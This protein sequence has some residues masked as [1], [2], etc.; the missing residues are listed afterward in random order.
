MARTV[1]PFFQG[2]WNTTTLTIPSVVV[3]AGARARIYFGITGSASNVVSV[4]GNGTDTYT[5]RH[6]AEPSGAGTDEVWL[7]QHTSPTPGTYNIVIT[8]DISTSQDIVGRV[9]LVTAMGGD[10]GVVSGQSTSAAP[11]VTVATESGKNEEV[12]AWCFWRDATSTFTADGDT[13]QVG[14]PQTAGAGGGAVNDVL[15]TATHA[16]SATPSGT[17]TAAESWY[18]IA[19][20]LNPVGAGGRSGMR[21][22]R[23][24]AILQHLGVRP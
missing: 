16:S 22:R 10:D 8:R 1:V 19:L 11:S 21:R 14:S 6:T 17:L 20:N 2:S 18:M 13:T 7:Y 15:L 9:V 12:E 5:L 24:R 23:L 4:I 3:P